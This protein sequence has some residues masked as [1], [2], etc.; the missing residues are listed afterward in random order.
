LARSFGITTYPSLFVAH[1]DR[2]AEV[3]TGYADAKTIVESIR[4][5]VETIKTKN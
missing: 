2:V 5:A 1:G 3:L 4:T